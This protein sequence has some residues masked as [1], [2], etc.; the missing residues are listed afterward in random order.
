MQIVVNAETYNAID[1]HVD[2]ALLTVGNSP[3]VSILQFL[4]TVTIE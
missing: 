4:D 1:G 2:P 3:T